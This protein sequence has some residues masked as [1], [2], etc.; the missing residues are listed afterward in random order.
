MSITSELQT[1]AEAGQLISDA[2]R[3]GY[4]ESGGSI[5]ALARRLR[6]ELGLSGTLK[7]LDYQNQPPG[8]AKTFAVAGSAETEIIDCGRVE[9]TR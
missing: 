8:P 6:R 7:R 3:V 1:H 5:D 4:V 9:G 2:A